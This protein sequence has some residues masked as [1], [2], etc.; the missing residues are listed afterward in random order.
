MPLQCPKCGN[1]VADDFIYCP[2]CA[3][4]LKPTAKTQRVSVSA[5]LILIATIGA[6]I[7]L[8]LSIQALL[9]IY[10][11]YPQ[12]VAQSWFVYDQL[13]TAMFAIQ[14][15]FGVVA[16]I[17]SLARRKYRLFL[18]SATACVAAGGS[19]WMISII[20]PYS[21]FWDSVLYYFLPVFLCPL[22]GLALAY[23]RRAEFEK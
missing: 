20:I 16:S 5:T 15:P 21:V 22:I 8:I 13:L 10:R 12:F 19:A 14:L 7:F 23:P 1:A 6:F 11:W 9:G 2:Y 4:G 3:H 17:L 18:I